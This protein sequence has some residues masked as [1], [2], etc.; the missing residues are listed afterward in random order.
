MSAV[1]TGPTLYHCLQRRLLNKAFINSLLYDRVK[2]YQVFTCRKSLWWWGAIAWQLPPYFPG[3]HRHSLH[4]PRGTDAAWGGMWSHTLKTYR[5]LSTLSKHAARLCTRVCHQGHVINPCTDM[6]LYWTAPGTF[7]T[8][9]AGE[10]GHGDMRPLSQQYY[11]VILSF[12]DLTIAV[13]SVKTDNDSHTFQWQTA[14]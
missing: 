12:N 3:W 9:E 13:A 11:P 14:Y 5:V 7:L 4:T 1:C 8:E 2:A 6:A 10:W